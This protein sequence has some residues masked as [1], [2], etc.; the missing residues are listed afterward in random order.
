MIFDLDATLKLPTWIRDPNADCRLFITAAGVEPDC[1]GDGHYLCREC[2]R[3]TPEAEDEKY[4]VEI[5]KRI[6]DV[7]MA[8]GDKVWITWKGK[9]ED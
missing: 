2:T 7:N 9:V 5:D 8:A 1:F 4:T 6:T 3:Y